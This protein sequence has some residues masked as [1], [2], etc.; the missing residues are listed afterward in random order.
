MRQQ[1]I[2]SGSAGKL[3]ALHELMYGKYGLLTMAI[4]P[5]MNWKALERWNRNKNTQNLESQKVIHTNNS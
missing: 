4:K 5:N 3:E 2:N 1:E